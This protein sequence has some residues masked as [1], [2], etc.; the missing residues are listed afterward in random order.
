MEGCMKT[1]NVDKLNAIRLV[2]NVDDVG[3]SPDTANGVVELWKAGAIS[4]ASVMAFGPDFEHSVALLSGNKI[5]IGVHLALNHGTGVLPSNRV[6]SLHSSNGN[7]WDTV[8]DTM[9]HMNIEE[10]RLEFD[11]QFRKLI[12]AGIKPSHLD[13]HMGLV[14]MNPRMLALY[15]ELARKYKISAALPADPYF[16]SVRKELSSSGLT[17]S[18]SLD[19]IYSLPTGTEE[20]LKNRAAEYKSLL[21]NL[22]PG[23]NHLYSHP[24]P[25]SEVVK[26]AFP[27]YSIRNHDY[28][29]FMSDEWKRML[30]ENNVELVS[31]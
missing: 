23:L 22:K 19:G 21:K 9:S 15:S 2:L 14:F 24:V 16:N 25:P 7:L 20:T 3:N 1:A 10:A 27:D 26:A 5:P 6:P 30:R 18:I 12:D 31:Y 13:S 8:E 4:S 11:A 29:L 28:E 17:T